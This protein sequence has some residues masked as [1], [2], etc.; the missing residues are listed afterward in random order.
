[1]SEYFMESADLFTA[2]LSIKKKTAGMYWFFVRCM[3][4]DRESIFM[5]L[6]KFEEHIKVPT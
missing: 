1:M 6:Q 5:P 3:N 4:I 2:Y